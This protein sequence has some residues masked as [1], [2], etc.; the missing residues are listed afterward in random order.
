MADKR[1]SKANVWRYERQGPCAVV[2]GPKSVHYGCDKGSAADDFLREAAD[3]LNAS[4]ARLAALEEIHKR[5]MLFTINERAALNGIRDL[6]APHVKP[7]AAKETDR[8]AFD[9]KRAAIGS[10]LR[11]AF[12]L[13]KHHNVAAALDE[14]DAAEKEFDAA[15]RAEGGE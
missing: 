15:V 9:R 14:W 2:D 7:E 13:G 8:Q 11:D 5:A 6:A 3:A 12:L 1:L 4:A 10:K